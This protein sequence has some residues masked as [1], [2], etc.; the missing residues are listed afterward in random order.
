MAQT[1]PCDAHPDVAGV[2]VGSN[3]QTGETFSFCVE[4]MATLGLTLAPHALP[5]DVIFDTLK[6]PYTSEPNPDAA[7]KRR[8]RNAQVEEAAPEPPAD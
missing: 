4:C 2:F 8:K 7:P 3:Q 6:I 5:P 1:I